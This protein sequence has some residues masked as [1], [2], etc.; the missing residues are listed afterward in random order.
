VVFG[1]R[2][3]LGRVKT[4]L[5]AAI[6]PEAATEIYRALLDHALGEAVAT[7]KKVT[8]A[9]AGGSTSGGWEAPAGLRV[10]SQVGSDLGA[11]MKNAFSDSFSAGADAVVLVG[12]DLPGLSATLICAAFEGLGRVPVVLGPAAD[13]GYWTVGQRRPGYDLFTGTPWST[14]DTLAVTKGRLADLGLDFEEL[15]VLRDLDTIHDVE[16]FLKYD[17]D[18]Q[19]GLVGAIRG[20]FRDQ[21]RER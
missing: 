14:P 8:L 3:V 10:T 17:S 16:A 13:G 19:G 7:G 2:P 12:S 15:P 5:A 11:R 21:R 4:R 18:R 6:G 1:R 20:A 9:L